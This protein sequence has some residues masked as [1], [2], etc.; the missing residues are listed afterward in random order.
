MLVTLS[1]V[2][3][4][5]PAAV[6]GTLSADTDETQQALTA[7]PTEPREAISGSDF[8]NVSTEVEVWERAA[9]PLRANP[10]VNSDTN[11]KNVDPKVTIDS[12]DIS[13]A[14]LDRD[15]V[16]IYDDQARIQL[17]FESKTFA[18][19]GDF[20][21]QDVQLLAAH[22]EEDTE[23]ARDLFNSSSTLTVNRTLD[24]LSDGTALNS[25]ASFDL[26][27]NYGTLNSDGEITEPYNLSRENRGAGFYVFFLVQDYKG[28]GWGVTDKGFE[29]TNGD[30]EVVNN[31]RVLGVEVATVHQQ[32]AEATLERNTYTAGS[33]LVFDVDAR[34][35]DGQ[36]THAIAIYDRNNLENRDVITELE[37]D[38][39]D[40]LTVD[41]VTVRREIGA[42]N[43]ISRVEGSPYV[44]GLGDLRDGRVSGLIAGA[45]II[46]F[47]AEQARLDEPLDATTN[48]PVTLDGSVTAVD[49][50]DQR[51]VTVDT[52]E[53]WTPGRYGGLYIATGEDSSEITSTRG[54]LNILKPNRRSQSLS[55]QQRTT[56]Q[57]P[58]DANA[59]NVSIQ[60][61]RDITGDV[62]V[63]QRVSPS[64]GVP[65]VLRQRGRIDPIYLDIDV[66][67]GAQDANATIEVTAKK[68]DLA[69]KGNQL[70]SNRTA[71]WHYK[72][73]QWT[74]LETKIKSETD[75]TVTLTATTDGFSSF[76]LARSTGPVPVV[77]PPQ[78]PISGNPASGGG[79]GGGVSPGS[80]LIF[81]KTDFIIGA[82]GI[83]ITVGNASQVFE[84]I[85]MQYFDTTAGQ[86]RVAERD[87]PQAS[88][89][90]P[91]SYD[92]VLAVLDLFP[93]DRVSTE[94]GS[95][96]L[97]IK[98]SALVAAGMSVD[99]LQIQQYN[100]NT[101]RWE[102]L[103]TE[104][105]ETEGSTVTIRADVSDFR[106]PFLVSTRPSQQ[107]TST[108]TATVSTLPPTTTEPGPE[109]STGTATLAPGESGETPT[110]ATEFPGLG[111]T[112]ALVAFVLVFVIV[113]GWRR[114]R[115]D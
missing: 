113:I 81:S 85:S 76:A 92:T 109:T 35:D 98:R 48:N 29:E 10:N 103:S 3:G 18:S 23:A 69:V 22:I 28:S 114:R 73:G 50:Q 67:S 63:E 45:Q 82:P 79:G 78:T 102:R 95:L 64:D 88:T 105:V 38:F 55:S 99:E 62:T 65:S 13:R 44:F 36:V 31:S 30:F 106:T 1:I 27:E 90:Y 34:Q 68:S 16:A 52:F 14:R 54:E 11:I 20:A 46:D 107:T 108:P 39:E 40:N 26:V 72:N 86:V 77:E 8:R 57:L 33:D 61:E 15:R 94:P 17:A 83:D 37:G 21:G 93:P 74:E 66:P 43:G 84:R 47:I 112:T 87:R 101:G 6:G 89:N 4:T 9:L 71:I 51:T 53:N 32:P 2:F 19:T 5:M 7:H 104:V 58:A 75:S 41:N 115:D 25:N 97:E 59:T 100:R 80:R 96:T 91:R 49:G 60:F 24:L 12:L 56:F 110:T 42:V 70:A 111:L